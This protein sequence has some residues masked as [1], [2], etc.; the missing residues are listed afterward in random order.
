MKTVLIFL[1]G[2]LM[3]NIFPQQPGADE[4]MSRSRDMSLTGSISADVNLTITEKNGTVRQ[5][6]ISMFSK[7]YG[8]VEKRFI[9]FQSPAD[10]RG[11]AM[12]IVDNKSSEDEMWIYLPALKRTRRISTS[13]KGKN[14]MSSEFTNADMSS[15]ALT[16]FRNAY[17]PGTE[18]GESWVIESFPV[19]DDIAR[20]YGFS[21]KISYVSRKDYHVSKMEFYDSD[22]KLLKVIDMKSIFQLGDGKYTVDNM[23]A[24]NTQT[25]RKSAIQMTNIKSGQDVDDA[26]FTIQNLEK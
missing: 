11:T 22:N 2:I 18:N 8:E 1:F 15:P 19:N 26:V 6:T 4:I 16:D 3:L 20:Q 5:R 7:T 14:F 9:K 13:D 21:K 24:E 25:G 12:L 23:V 17:S 10:I